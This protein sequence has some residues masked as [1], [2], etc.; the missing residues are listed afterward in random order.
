MANDNEDRLV[1]E[2]DA[3]R[4]YLWRLPEGRFASCYLK[5]IAKN[6]D[7]NKWWMLEEGSKISRPTCDAT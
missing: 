7:Y 5:I 2:I 3:H 6:I 1:E 4:Q